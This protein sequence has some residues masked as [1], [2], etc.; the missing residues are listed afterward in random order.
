M[1]GNQWHDWQTHNRCRGM[2]YKTGHDCRH[3]W[4]FVRS[5]TTKCSNEMLITWKS[6]SWHFWAQTS[7]P[8]GVAGLAVSLV[9][10]WADTRP[11][12][13]GPGEVQ[14]P[15]APPPQSWTEHQLNYSQ[16]LTNICSRPPWRWWRRPRSGWGCAGS[17]RPGSGSWLWRSACWR[18]SRLSPASA[19]A[20]C[21]TNTV[22]NDVN[23]EFRVY[24]K[25]MYFGSEPCEGLLADLSTEVRYL[26]WARGRDLGQVLPETDQKWSSC[27]LFQIKLSGDK[28][29]MCDGRRSALVMMI[30]MRTMM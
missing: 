7:S 5:W 1:F 18:R 15:S 3:M 6:S 16:F 27:A 26:Q 17:R 21:R 12:A 24:L 19:S 4:H 11:S 10:L 9:R 13:S 22:S 8:G 23:G 25:L 20:V 14:P 2:W 28:Q 29:Q 30:T